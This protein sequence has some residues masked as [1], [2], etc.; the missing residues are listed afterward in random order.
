MSEKSR[1]EVKLLA[2]EANVLRY[3]SGYYRD[4]IQEGKGFKSCPVPRMPLHGQGRWRLLVLC[5]HQI[6]DGPNDAFLL[7]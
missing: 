4:A 6:M 5:I 1:V 3:A 2:D 7:F